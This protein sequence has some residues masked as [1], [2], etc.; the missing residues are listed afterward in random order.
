[1]PVIDED[2]SMSPGPGYEG[3]SARNVRLFHASWDH[4][5]GG[6]PNTLSMHVL[7]FMVLVMQD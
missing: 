1:M 4:F 3:D 7:S 5:L 2:K 6:G